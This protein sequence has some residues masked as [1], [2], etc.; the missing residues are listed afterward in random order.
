LDHVL[1][2]RLAIAA[3]NEIKRNV[4][5][6]TLKHYIES[7]DHSIKQLDEQIA[8]YRRLVNEKEDLKNRMLTCRDAYDERL[9]AKDA[10]KRRIEGLIAA[11]F[12]KQRT[13]DTSETYFHESDGVLFK[14][15]DGEM[16]SIDGVVL[17][18]YIPFDGFKRL[19]NGNGTSANR[20]TV[21][22]IEGRTSL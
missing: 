13:N 14:G 6:G 12:K 3:G 15:D 8:K 2:D 5:G 16:Y 9:K 18:T 22:M 11:R 21:N 19:N 7:S 10:R 1:Q 4:D 20:L 17:R